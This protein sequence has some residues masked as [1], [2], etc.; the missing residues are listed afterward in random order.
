VSRLLE[1]RAALLDLLFETRDHDLKLI[2]GG[3]YGIY[4]KHEHV[5]SSDIRTL[6]KEWPEP[7]STNDLDLFLRPELLIKSHMLK[8][9]REALTRLGYKEVEGAQKYQFI[10]PTLERG[11]R[12]AIK[13]DLLTGPQSEFA[14]STARADERRVRPSPSIDLHA[15][16]VDEALTLEE[17]LLFVKLEGTTSQGAQHQAAV[18]IPLTLTSA[19]MKLFAFRDRFEDSDKEF[20]RYHALDL[21]TIVA[22]ATE[23]EWETSLSLVSKHRSAPK[24]VEAGEIVR[25]FFA[26]L[27]APGVLRLRENPYYRPE[28]QLQDFLSALHELF[29]RAT[30]KGRT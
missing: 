2:I 5:I 26:S 22:L 1:L 12:G 6:L 30:E 4:L 19:M 25:S 20:G 17:G 10:L 7:R 24:M 27:S 18:H 3:G 13:V 14:G 15:H 11:S 9:L 8:P 16:P 28:L 21:Y 29:L 23:A